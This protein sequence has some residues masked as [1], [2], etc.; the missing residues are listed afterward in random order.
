MSAAHL[1]VDRIDGKPDDLHVPALELRLD[2]RHVAELG[3]AYR[4]EVPGVRE[5]HG[6]GVADPV[7][8]AD[9]ALGR[10]RLEVRCGVPDLQ[11]HFFL[12]PL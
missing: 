6:P 2:L 10:L 12:L 3:R 8:E 9:L 1:V 5:Q 4:R 7:V 11:T